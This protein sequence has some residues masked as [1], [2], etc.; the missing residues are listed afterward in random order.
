MIT[1]LYFLGWC[2]FLCL[3]LGSFLRACILAL[4]S[5]K[6]SSKY[7]GSSKKTKYGLFRTIVSR[8]ATWGKIKADSRTKRL[9]GGD[10]SAIIVVII[11]NPKSGKEFVKNELGK[12][13]E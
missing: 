11:D 9:Y 1:L 13:N 2:Y 5:G 6:L 7:E 12:I 10:K 8:F 3:N 4:S